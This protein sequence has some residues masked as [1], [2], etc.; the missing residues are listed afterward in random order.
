MFV[1]LKMLVIFLT[2]GPKLRKLDERINED[3]ENKYTTLN[4]KLDDLL[5][6]TNKKPHRSHTMRNHT[7]PRIINL[8]NTKITQEQSQILSLGPSYAV[9]QTPKKY[10]NEPIIETENAI[11][12]LEPKMQNTYRHLA[13]KQI[14]QIK[15]TNNQNILHKRQQHITNN[16]KEFMQSEDIR[17]AE[18]DKSKAIVLI[19][20][21]DLEKKLYTFIQDK[22]IKQID[23]DPTNKFQKQIQHT[24]QQCKLLLDKRAHKYLFNM[25]ASAP[26]F[27]AYIKTHKEQAPIR[28]V[29]N[30]TQAP[31]HR[32]ARCLS[33]KLD[34]LMPLPN[35]Y[36]TKNSTEIAE[37]IVNMKIDKNLKL[38][39]LDIKDLYV[40]LP[41][42]EV[43]QVTKRWLLKTPNTHEINGQIIGLLKVITEQNYFQYKN[44]YFKPEKGVTMGSPIPGKI[45]EIYL[46]NIEEENIKQ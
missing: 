33:K 2:P 12:Q 17:K 22:N 42:Q 24:T 32:I 45:A 6:R 46:Q 43:L 37:E 15:E 27:N 28:P 16:L 1:L 36:M 23:K 29:I 8:T 3:M 19:N 40:N 10:I 44:Q 5:N 20:R 35:T 31:S 41:I 9:E 26:Q 25:K 13:T 7:Q 11:R 14:K 30:N 38:M 21:G 18:A 4:T 34:S 39:T